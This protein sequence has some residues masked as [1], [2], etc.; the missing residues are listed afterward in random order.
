MWTYSGRSGPHL[1]SS[2]PHGTRAEVE[3]NQA[4]IRHAQCIWASSRPA[5]D[6]PVETYLR[7]RAITAPVP[8][9]IRFHPGLRHQSGGHHPAMISAVSIWPSCKITGVHRTFLSRDGEGWKKAPVEPNKMMLGLCQG[10]AVRLARHGDTLM[11]AEGIETA[12]AAAQAKA[13]PTWAALSAAGLAAVIV[14]DEVTD[15]VILADGD[16]AGEQ[17]AMKAA[18]RLW[19]RGRRVRIARPPPGMD[20]AD[21]L[22]ADSPPVRSAA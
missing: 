17:A 4:R 9:T 10:G 11:I 8:P 20:F 14:P 1:P 5:G 6:T 3:D 13:L 21:L 19:R 22:I 16:M 12:A 2:V 7:G 18:T 15:L